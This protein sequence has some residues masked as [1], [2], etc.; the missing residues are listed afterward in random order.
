MRLG[1]GAVSDAIFIHEPAP[2]LDIGPHVFP[3]EKYALLADA[4]RALGIPASRF[5]RPDAVLDEDIRRVHTPAYLADLAAARSTIRTVPSELPVTRGVI[6]GFR[7]MIGG[8]TRAADLAWREERWTMHL[9][10]G[11]HHAFAD[12]AE[13]FCYYHD[14]AIA[15]R[16]LQATAGLSRCAVVDTDLHQ[17]N[18]T[19]AIFA[20][21]DSVFTFSIH[22]ERLYPLKERSDL[23]IGL[24]LFTGDAEYL[25]LLDG[26]LDVVFDRASPE[27]IF[28]VAG[29]DPYLDDQLGDLKLTIDGLRE[30][31]RRVIARAERHGIPGVVTLA[32]GYA[33]RVE[34]T[35]RIHLGTAEEVWATYRGGE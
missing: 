18:G 16:R 26:A 12:H 9:G 33:R 21:D 2:P 25:E 31:D 28:Y 23:D 6:D 30:R 17:G 10:G 11:F 19:A 24:D 1:R 34:D 8:T 22:Q 7:R 29:A 5:G 32:G 13:G 35:V 14:V 15:I 27:M 3:T 4:I 20:G